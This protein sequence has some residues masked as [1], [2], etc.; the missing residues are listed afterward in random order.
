MPSKTN[1]TA[2]KKKK[3]D[4]RWG[5]ANA[6]AAAAVTKPIAKPVARSVAGGGRGKVIA[7]EE[8]QARKI[9]YTTIL[10]SEVTIVV[11]LLWRYALPAPCTTIYVNISTVYILI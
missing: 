9:R 5:N 8:D 2:S 1:K 6:A 4:T 3:K 11:I 7:T 10:V